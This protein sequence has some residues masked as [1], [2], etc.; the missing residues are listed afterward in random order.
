MLLPALLSGTP[1]G[2]LGESLMAGYAP[3]CH[4]DPARSFHVG[5]VQL[6]A[7][8]RCVALYAGGLLGLLLAP[9]SGLV[10][11][12]RL[13]PRWVLLVGLAPLAADAL[14]PALGLWTST[15]ASRSATGLVAGALTALFILPGLTEVLSEIA[16]RLSVRARNMEMEVDT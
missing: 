4:Q 5:G 2:W 1:L 13:A 10:G 15:L 8:S 12:R 6:L 7:C 16:R 11:R 14:L 3:L 9:A